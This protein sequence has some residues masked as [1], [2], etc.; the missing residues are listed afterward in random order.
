MNKKIFISAPISGFEDK[1]IYLTFRDF[2]IHLIA[3]LREAG[4]EVC[5]ELEQISHTDNYDSP[6]KSVE[7]DFANIASSDIFLMIHPK[8]MQTSSLI[9]LGFA[10]ANKKRIVIVGKEENLPYLAKG[11]K[12]SPIDT[13]IIEVSDINKNIMSRIIECVV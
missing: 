5:S 1:K 7:S 6:T 10:C 13:K 9:E 3:V 11:L 8:R 12:E 2:I 4:F